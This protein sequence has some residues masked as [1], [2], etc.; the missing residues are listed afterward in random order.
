MKLRT[1]AFVDRLRAARPDVLVVVA[2]GRILSRT[3]LQV[4][5]LAP[6]NVHFSMLP[7]YRGA[8]PVQWALAH[9]DST[10]GVT[11]MRIGEAL[12]EGD[13]YLQEEMKIDGGEHTPALLD[14]LARLGANL[15][16]A[17]LDGIASGSLTPRPQ[18]PSCATYAPSLTRQ[19]G[20]ADF[21]MPA[22]EIEGRVRGFDPWPGVWAR[23][24]GKRL[25]IVQAE[26]VH[27]E[28]VL[29][30]P[31]RVVA[32]RGPL[33]V[34][35]CGGGTVLGVRAV[36]PEGRKIVASRDAVNGRQVMPGDDLV[37]EG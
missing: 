25:R 7:R 22:R 32:L 28:S 26:A 23:R 20:V 11:T 15:L 17:T 12:D 19:D 14:R 35:A 30:P 36:Q 3:A 29:E 33:L 21:S 10:T 9:G 37:G 16:V 13:V 1:T 27:G 6:V 24:N 2:Y 4:P 34:V 5:R 31:G 8:A 18:D